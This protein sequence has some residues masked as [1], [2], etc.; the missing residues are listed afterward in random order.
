MVHVITVITVLEEEEGRVV[1]MWHMRR[2]LSLGVHASVAR[3]VREVSQ[4][5]IYN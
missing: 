3:C 1:Q 5:V 4:P 2:A